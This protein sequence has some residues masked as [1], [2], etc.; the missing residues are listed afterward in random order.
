MLNRSI[1]GLIQPIKTIKKNSINSII[2][3][4]NMKGS[5]TGARDSLVE[6]NVKGAFIR[7]DSIFRDVISIEHDIYK[8]ESNRYH[9]Y[10]ANACPWANRCLTVLHLKGLEN[11]IDVSI[12]HPTWQKTKPDDANDQHCGWAFITDTSTVFQSSKGYGSFGLDGCTID[13]VNNFKTIRDIYEQNGCNGPKFTVPI[14]YDTKTNKIVNNESSEIIRIFNTAFNEYAINKDL[15]LYPENLRE[16]IDDVNNWIYHDINNGVYK[17]GF[18]QSQEAYDEACDKLYN[19]LDKVEDILSNNRYLTGNILT[20]ADIRLFM[21]LVRFD[22]VYVVYFKC[23]KKQIKE[24]EN[25][26]NYCRELYQIPEIKRTINIEHIKMHYFTSHPVLNPYS[27]I[28]KGPNSIANF[29][30]PHNR[31]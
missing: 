27:V 15:D 21:T 12:V 9:L 18:A 20:E 26:I 11:I 10:I 1:T 28:P 25:I 8:P 5:S 13:K 3:Y 2:R 16:K 4:N 29:L 7:S 22:E 17:C 30:L 24:Y 6:V 14:L 31:G 23:N 19:A